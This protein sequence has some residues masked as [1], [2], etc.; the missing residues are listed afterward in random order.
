MAKKRRES[1]R[2]LKLRQPDRSAPSEATL[3]DLAE[4]RGLFAQAMQKEEANRKASRAATKPGDHEA[5]DDS[6]E[7]SPTVERVLETVLWSVSL[8]MLHF[9]L[10]VLVHHQF[11][12]DRIQ[13]T[14]VGIR[15]VQALMG[16][17]DS[18]A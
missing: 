6:G 3:I 1:P 16:K 5:E 10:D 15:A 13:W 18:A 14:K 8:A 2:R 4:Q 17:F 11:S 12:M 9:T 7:L